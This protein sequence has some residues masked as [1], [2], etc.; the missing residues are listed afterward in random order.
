MIAVTAVS[1]GAGGAALWNVRMLVA[2]RTPAASAAQT[3]QLARAMQGSFQ[4]NPQWEARMAAATRQ[5][6][7]A[8]QQQGAAFRQTLSQQEADESAALQAQGQMNQDALN[9]QHQAGMDQLNAQGAQQTSNFNQQQYDRQTGQEAELRYINDQ[10]CVQW[11]DAAHTRCA[12]T[13]PN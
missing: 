6:M 1:Q 5:A 2:Y 11:A 8:Q 3:D 13:A 12:V 4:R 7:A 9:A 10:T